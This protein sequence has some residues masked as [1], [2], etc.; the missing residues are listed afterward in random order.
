MN[1]TVDQDDGVGDHDPDQHECTH[2]RGYIQGFS[3]DQQG[4]QCAD[5]DEWQGE[6][7]GERRKPAAER[8]YEHE[9]YD[10]NR[11]SHGKAKL[12]KCIV[13]LSC[14]SAEFHSDAIRLVIGVNFVLKTF[15]G[16]AYICRDD[17][18]TDLDH[19]FAVNAHDGVW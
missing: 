9:I 16:A 2:K 6:E 10:R 4:D 19:H 13:N 14:D 5:D 3:A 8:Y 1:N 11:R 12:G 18:G 7:D 15:G 17:I